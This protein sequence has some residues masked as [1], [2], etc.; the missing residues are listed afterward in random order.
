MAKPGVKEMRDICND[1]DLVLIV[2]PEKLEL[3]VSSGVLMR[4]SKVFAAMLG[5]NWKESGAG[6]VELPEDHGIAMRLSE[7]NFLDNALFYAARFWLQ[8]KASNL[9]ALMELT[10]VAYVFQDEHAFKAFTKELVL[11]YGSP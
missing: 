5:P 1:G 11:Q 4:S 7:K 8:Q 6:K 3:Q 2:S 10:T 9:Q